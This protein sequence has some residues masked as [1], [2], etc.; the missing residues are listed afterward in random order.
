MNRLRTI[1]TAV[2]ALIGLT[3]TAQ[4]EI[5]AL[6]EYDGVKA[7]DQI[8]VTLVESSENKAVVTGD[9]VDE[10]KIVNNDGTLKIRMELDNFLDGNETE[11][12]LYHT[13]EINMLDSNEGAKITSDNQIDSNYLV[14]NAQEGGTVNVA[15]NTTNLDVKAVTG[16][17]VMANGTAPNLEV[18]VRSGG[19][20]SGKELRAQQADVN[21]FAGGDAWVHADEYVE[22]TVTAGGTIEIFGNPENV[23]KNKTFGGSIIVRQ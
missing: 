12:T 14:L 10:V 20:F 18:V 5:I 2:T 21:V 17:E 22:A 6:Q 3:A 7:F 23:S 19:E 13:Q 1:I 11:V 16:G 9:D 4:T 15:V 8:N